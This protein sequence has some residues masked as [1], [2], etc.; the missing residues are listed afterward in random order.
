MASNEMGQLL[1]KGWAMLEECC[2]DCQ[3]PLMRSPDKS[4]ELCVQ[5]KKDYKKKQ[6]KV[7]EV[8]KPQPV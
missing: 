2:E 4:S 6:G 1:L 3:V 7:A 5:C 8:A